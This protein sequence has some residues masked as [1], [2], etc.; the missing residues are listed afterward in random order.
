MKI[1]FT[2]FGMDSHFNAL[3][4]LAWAFQ[5]AGHDV[6]IA[7]HPALVDGITRAGL[8]AVPVGEDHKVADVMAH[9]AMGA[10]AF[11]S[12]PNYLR[13]DVDAL[14]A[15]FLEVSGS[16]LTAAFYSQINNDSMVDELVSFANDW[17]PDLILWE[18][19]T[20]AGAIAATVTQT[21]HVR[22][23]WGPDLFRAAHERFVE[24]KPD[25]AEDALYEW[26]S[27]S[28]Q[29]HGSKFAPSTLWGLKSIDLMP[30]SVRL[31]THSHLLPMR[32]IP[33]NG[34]RPAVHP[35][36]IRRATDR[37]RV[38]LTQ[39]FTERSTGFTNVGS[40]SEL[41]ACLS[42]LDIEIVATMSPEHASQIATM[43]DRVR[44]VESVPMQVLLP[45]CAAVVHH[46][47]AGTWSTAAVNGVPQLNMAWQW[48]DVY[49]AHRL[50]Q[51]GAG[52]YLPDGLASGVGSIVDAVHELITDERYRRSSAQLAGVMRSMPAPA[53]VVTELE[54]LVRN[55]DHRPSP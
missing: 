54:Q 43:P 15:D 52:R 24:I 6:R 34:P 25:S 4:P 45:T 42:D 8:C 28:L 33:Y 32:Y 48:D 3:V 13:G 1:L 14:D 53:E 31:P 11:H 37:P 35:E 16:M 38:C 46:G 20:L 36:W 17:A 23:L 22:L 51:L 29:R 19:F 10:F 21:P 9:A 30:P 2:S 44:V 55:G 27:W 7:S 41:L 26:M 50:D 39:G 12:N 40:M 18:A 49:R 47:G 5:N